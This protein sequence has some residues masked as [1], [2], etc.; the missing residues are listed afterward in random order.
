[1]LPMDVLDVCRAKAAERNI[2]SAHVAAIVD[3]E[4]RGL[5]FDPAGS[6]RPMILF[7]QHLFARKL[8]G[9]ALTEA[10][11]RGLATKSHKK[12]KYPKAQADRWKQI[13]A[14]QELCHEFGVSDV[15]AFESASYGVGQVLGEHWNELG[16]ASF[17]DFYKTM[18]SGAGGQID[19]MLKF[20]KVNGL[21]DELREGRWPAFFRG[22]NGPDYARLGYHLRIAKALALYGG[23]SAEPDGMLRMGAK[24]AKVREIQ[25]LLV[26][27]GHQV[28]IDGDYGPATKKAVRAFQKAH[29]ITVDGVVGPQTQTALAKFR[30]GV[31]DKPGEQ[32]VTEVK[33]VIESVVVGGGGTI[34]IETAKKTV[35]GA[36]DEIVGLGLDLPVVDYLIAGLSTAAAVLAVAAIGYGLYAW[37][38][39]KKTVEV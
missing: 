37:L 5:V 21:E 35:E 11:R 7:E 15:A 22:Y 32:K 20:V 13:E 30:Q 8:S 39:S 6:G 34:A 4:S 3:V 14:A 19:I 10:L 24:G 9:D 2:P 1:M 38:R 16:F 23:E 36:K 33:E 28:K 17:G 29:G 31:A 26:R 25:A 12:N 27:A 18:M